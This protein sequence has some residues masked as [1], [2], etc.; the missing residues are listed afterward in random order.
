MVLLDLF[1]GAGGAA[2]GYYRAGFQTIVGVDSAKQP[3][4][5]FEFHQADALDFC[6]AHGKEFDAIH[7]SPP[8][9]ADSVTRPLSNGTHPMLVGTVRALLLAAAKPFII[10]NVMGAPLLNPLLL[11][12]T[13]FGLQVLRHRLF[14]TSPILWF[15]PYLCNHS[16]RAT[17]SRLRRIHGITRTPSLA[18]GFQYVTVVG[19]NYLKSEGAKAMQIDWM[20]KAELSQAVPP[21]YTEYIGREIL[22]L[23]Q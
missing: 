1:C 22:K 12:G 14:E 13:M 9:Q 8:C 4:Y 7:A 15:P 20:T 21:A 17:G 23:I 2:M 5:P 19:C 10:G 11:C 18:D 16:G 3:H 6:A